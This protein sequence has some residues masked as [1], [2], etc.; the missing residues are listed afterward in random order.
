MSDMKKD[1]VRAILQKTRNKKVSVTLQLDADVV[2]WFINQGDEKAHINK[3]L[4]TYMESKTKQQI[5]LTDIKKIKQLLI[6][7]KYS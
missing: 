6:A 7:G 2:N 5:K 1:Q 4:R 3:T